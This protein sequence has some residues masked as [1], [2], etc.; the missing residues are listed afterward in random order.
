MPCVCAIALVA[1]A[2]IPIRAHARTNEHTATAQQ[3][4]ADHDEIQLRDGSFVRGRIVAFEREK[5]VTIVVSG[6]G[7]RRVIAWQDIAELRRG[8]QPPPTTPEPAA[9]EPSPAEPAPVAPTPVTAQ[10]GAPQIYLDVRSSR[11]VSLFEIAPES[12]WGS[13]TPGVGG[14]ARNVM[15]DPICEAPCDQIVDGRKGQSFVVSGPRLSPSKPFTLLDREGALTLDVTP[16]PQ[17]V[18]VAAWTVTPLGVL[19]VPAGVLMLTNPFRDPGEPVDPDLQ[20]G[21]LVTLGVAGA[22]VITG[23]LLAVFSRTKVRFAARR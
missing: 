1:P 22:A 14:N 13:S 3:P 6:S 12:E 19:L 11:S 9:S 20:T 16:R 15:L 5:S 4:A 2:T 10:R 18:R 7:D 21:G 23:V 8:N 17:G